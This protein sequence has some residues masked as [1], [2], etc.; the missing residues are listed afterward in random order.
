MSLETVLASIFS[1]A[2][3]ATILRASTPIILPPLA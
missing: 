2:F 1:A 3:I